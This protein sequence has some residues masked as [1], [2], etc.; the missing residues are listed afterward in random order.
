MEKTNKTKMTDI[1]G[2]RKPNIYIGEENRIIEQ[3]EKYS[4]I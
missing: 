2:K 3:E 1:G 4:N